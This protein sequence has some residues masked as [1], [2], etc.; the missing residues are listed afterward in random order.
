M[1]AERRLG[2]ARH[3]CGVD[4]HV[5][6]LVRDAGMVPLDALPLRPV[7]GLLVRWAACRDTASP[8]G[9][10]SQTCSLAAA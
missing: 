3:L 2:G 7:H 10:A 4:D 6:G 5:H 9:G 1:G 8:A